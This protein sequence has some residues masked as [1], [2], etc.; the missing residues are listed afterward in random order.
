[1]EI[2]TEERTERRA[3]S[4]AEWARLHGMGEQTVYHAI[5]TGRLPSV[6]LG[7]RWL[8]PHDALDRMMEKQTKE[9]T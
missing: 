1:M 5:R 9:T 6:R 3:Y 4:P 8:V 7:R 2:Q